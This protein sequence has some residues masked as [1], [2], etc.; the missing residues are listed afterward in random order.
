MYNSFFPKKRSY[1]PRC[2]ENLTCPDCNGTGET[3][4]DVSTVNCCGEEQ[5]GNHCVHCGR[6][7]ALEYST[8][9]K[10]LRCKG[11]GSLGFEH[12]SSCKG[13][14]FNL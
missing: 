9:H 11:T 4:T 14:N 3:G 10:C 2:G 8:K 12:M 1:C 13:T 5:K 7:L 6:Y